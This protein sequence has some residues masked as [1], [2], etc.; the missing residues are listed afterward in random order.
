MIYTHLSS[1]RTQEGSSLVPME[2]N[3]ETSHLQYFLT[4]VAAVFAL[5]LCLSSHAAINNTPII[6]YS[7]Q[8][9]DMTACNAIY[10]LHILIPIKIFFWFIYIKHMTDEHYQFCLY[11]TT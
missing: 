9:A 2:V 7:F 8:W 4:S 6:S 5:S 10:Q 11:Y 3:L 1:C